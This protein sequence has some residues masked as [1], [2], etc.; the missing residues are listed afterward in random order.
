[1]PGFDESLEI[2]PHLEPPRLDADETLPNMLHPSYPFGRP[3]GLGKMKAVKGGIGNLLL[4]RGGLGVSNERRGRGGEEWE[5]L[6][7][8]GLVEVEVGKEV[9]PGMAVS[10]LLTKVVIHSFTVRVA[11]EQAGSEMQDMGRQGRELMVGR[12]KTTIPTI[13]PTPP[14]SQSR[15]NIDPPAELRKAST[16]YHS[17]NYL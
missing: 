8:G 7:V 9:P 14:Q 4:G 11:C 10:S 1:M 17:S 3:V 2:P 6:D 12:Q 5:E 15:T 16:T 13:T